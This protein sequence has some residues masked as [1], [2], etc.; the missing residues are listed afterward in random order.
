VQ[1]KSAASSAYAARCSDAGPASRICDRRD[2]LSFRKHSLKLKPTYYLKAA[3]QSAKVWLLLGLARGSG[4][5][6]PA[7]N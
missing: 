6:V 2:L 5:K 1:T 4:S 3:L 7:P